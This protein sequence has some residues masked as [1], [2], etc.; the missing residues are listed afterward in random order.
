MKRKSIKPFAGALGAAFIASAAVPLVSAGVTQPFAVNPL[1]SGYE[2]A[3]FDQPMDQGMD[4]GMDSG[5]KSKSDKEGSCA[6]SKAGKEASGDAG[7]GTAAGGEMK[8]D[9]SA[10]SSPKSGKEGNCGSAK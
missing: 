9:D 6:A 3:N 2:L 1:A 10:M 8:H 4:K 5:G 7:K